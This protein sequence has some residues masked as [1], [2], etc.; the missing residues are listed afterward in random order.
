MVTVIPVTSSDRVK[1]PI[2]II[3]K[4]KGKGKEDKELVQQSDAIIL[5]SDNGW[6]QGP[7]TIDFLKRNFKG[8]EKEVLIWDSYNAITRE[9]KSLKRLRI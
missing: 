3:F 2:T 1:N 8:E 6:M 4:G 7:T 9:M 5:F